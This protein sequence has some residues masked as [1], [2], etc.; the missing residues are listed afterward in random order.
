ME[1]AQD[2]IDLIERIIKS[3]RKYQN[4]EDL[5]DD[6]LNEACQRSYAI[7]NAISSDATLEVYLKKVA[8]TS[9][10]NVLKNSGRLRRTHTGYVSTGEVP[11]DY[12]AT[13][14]AVDYSNIKVEYTVP[15]TQETPEDVSMKN[16]IL[17]KVV[18]YVYAIHNSDK[19]KKYLEIY[20]LRYENGMTQKEIANELG[21]SQSEVSKRL[22]KLMDRVKMAFN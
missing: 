16:E 10:L 21:L 9:I 22:F 12:S 17:Q 13:S 2:K 4:N 19:D 11:V 6:F 3:D 20:K 18:D 15:F 14:S 8:T 7:V 1:L 5:F